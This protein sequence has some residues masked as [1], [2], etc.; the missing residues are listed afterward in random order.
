M[1]FCK[2]ASILLRPI[3]ISASVICPITSRSAVWAAQAMATL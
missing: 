1:I 3:R 2:S